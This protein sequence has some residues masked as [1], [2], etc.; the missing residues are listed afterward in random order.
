[1]LGYEKPGALAMWGW[2]GIGPPFIRIGKRVY[3]EPEALKK[4]IADNR[5]QTTE[6][7]NVKGQ[8]IKIK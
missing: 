1:M 6:S 5:V 8:L 4:W 3:Y 7:L 2:R